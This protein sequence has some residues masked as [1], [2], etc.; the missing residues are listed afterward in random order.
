MTHV[1]R[2]LLRKVVDSLPMTQPPLAGNELEAHYLSA[3]KINFFPLAFHFHSL[4]F[5]N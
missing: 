3:V 2:E 4:I 5:V 1:P